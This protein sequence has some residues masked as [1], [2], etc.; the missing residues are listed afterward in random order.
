MAIKEASNL[1]N[2][3]KAGKG[4][5]GSL[6]ED[7]WKKLNSLGDFGAM[8]SFTSRGTFNATVLGGVGFGPADRIASATE[9]T[10]KNT[11]AILQNAKRQGGRF[12]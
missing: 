7:L 3:G 10:A 12:T 4:G 6:W 5:V 1:P 8:G 9:A 2:G 11:G